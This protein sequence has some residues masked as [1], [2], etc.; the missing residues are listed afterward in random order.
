M[1][2][3][4]R[5]VLYARDAEEAERAAQAAFARVRALEA[6]F[7]DYDETSEARRLAEGAP[8]VARASPELLEVTALALELS[9]R[10]GGAFDVTVGP[11]TRLWRRAVRQGEPPSKEDLAAARAAVGSDKLAVDRAAGT[12]SLAAPGMRL[13]YGAIAKGYALDAALAVLARHGIDRALVDGGGDVA[14]GAPPPGAE[15]WL[16]ALAGPPGGADGAVRLAWQSVATSGDLARG[17]LVGAEPVSHIVDPLTGA[18]LA[19]RP[20]TASAVAR[21]GALA[22]GLATA[23]LLLG[24]ERGPA[25]VASWPGAEAR[26]VEVCPDGPRAWSSAG[27]PALVSSPEPVPVPAGGEP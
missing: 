10:T 27:F 1:G 9:A 17:G 12:L 5:I 11:L 2:T 22:D 7:S 15:G 20:R 4:F 26:L 6:V 13:D 25:V 8:C 16:V 23:L 24:A 18:A 19:A 3:T 21:E 14:C